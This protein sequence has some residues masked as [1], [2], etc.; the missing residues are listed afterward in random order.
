MTSI[1]ALALA[2]VA[3]PA[4]AQT[5]T[6]VT[7][8]SQQ[9]APPPPPPSTSTT[10]TTQT[11]PQPAPPGGTTVVVN[12][13]DPNYVPPPPPSTRT[14]VRVDDDP[15]GVMSAPSGRS[16]VAIIATDALYGGVA[17]GLIGGGVTLI[18]Q[19]NN[20]ARNLMVGAGI[21]I[22]AGAAYGVYESATQPTPRRA[23]VDADPGASNVNGLS[24]AVASGRF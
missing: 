14:Q 23:V 2:L 3:F 16:A 22:L 9:E 13:N 5:T 6:T 10:V 1:L 20:W 17:G 4:L 8:P 21:G 24:L 12:P 19:G 11:A 15:N 7:T 18:D